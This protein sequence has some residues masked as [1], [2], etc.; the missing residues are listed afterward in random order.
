MTHIGSHL[1]EVPFKQKSVLRFIADHLDQLGFSNLQPMRVTLHDSCG[2]G[3]L[4]GDY[5]SPRRI[6]KAIPGIELVEMEHARSDAP[7]CGGPGEMFFPGKG[8]ALREMRIGEAEETG[9]R[10]LV[11]LCVGCESSYLKCK[12]N[13]PFAVTSI[14]TTLG[15]SLGIAREHRLGPFYVSKDVEGAL[16]ELK[17]VIGVSGSKYTREDYRAVLKRI[18]GA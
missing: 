10:E 5:E 9:A 13:K 15:R 4:C 3:R 18:L 17:D 12:G 11:T 6:L 8:K 14:I 1:V 16:E 7:C 2:H